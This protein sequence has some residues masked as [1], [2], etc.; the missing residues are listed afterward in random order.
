M[1]AILAAVLISLP[2]CAETPNPAAEL[3]HGAN[4]FWE[5]PYGDEAGRTPCKHLRKQHPGG[6][7]APCPC[8]K[9]LQHPG[10][11]EKKIECVHRKLL[12]PDGDEEK[13]PCVHR[14]LDGSAKHGDGDTAR[15]P[16]G[17]WVKD[18]PDGD[19]ET[20][21]CTHWV[22]KHPDGE[23]GTNV[24]CTHLTAEHRDGDA[25]LKPCG[26]RLGKVASDSDPPVDFYTD[27]AAVTAGVRDGV[28]KLKELGVKFKWPRPLCVFYRE[29]INGNPDD[30]NDP[31]WSHCNMVDSVL[32]VTKDPSDWLA[33]NGPMTKGDRTNWFESRKRGLQV[34]IRHELGHAIVGYK[35]VL[36][37]ADFSPHSLFME[38]SAG[39]AISEGWADF[40]AVALLSDRGAL[41]AAYKGWTVEDGETLTKAQKPDGSEVEVK[42]TQKVEFRVMCFLWDCYDTASSTAARGRTTRDETLQLK[43]DEIFAAWSP[44]GETLLNSPLMPD[45]R[46]FM[47]RLANNKPDLKTELERVFEVHMK[48]QF[49]GR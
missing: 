36:A 20:V 19:R 31:F 44:S 16:C 3:P 27:D 10:G 8:P 46:S 24:P 37:M 22:T 47:N 40:V 34:T 33:K 5:H 49:H 18:H 4:P 43:F 7:L 30:N 41:D 48:D 26:H 21:P 25:V 32:V 6:D 9:S 2:L 11:D 15:K 17:H 45:A 42:A 28:K 14:N 29:P 13:V 1:K 38:Q 35:C 23:P 39:G 12:H